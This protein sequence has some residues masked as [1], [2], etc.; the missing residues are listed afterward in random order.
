[1]PSA[2][3]ERYIGEG[4]FARGSVQFNASPMPLSLVTFLCGHK[5]VTPLKKKATR[6]G[7]LFDHL[8]KEVDRVVE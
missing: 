7:G 3:R 2:C 5:K 6:E 1:M 8:T 4:D